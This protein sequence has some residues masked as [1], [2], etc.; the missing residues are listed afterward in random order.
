M[1]TQEMQ[2]ARAKL[3]SLTDTIANAE[4]NLRVLSAMGQD[5]IELQAG[6]KKA[7]L[8]RDKLLNAIRQEELRGETD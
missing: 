6:L 5:T 4:S 3:Q 7:M 8:D 1:L 2:V